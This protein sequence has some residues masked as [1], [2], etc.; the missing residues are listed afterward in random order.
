[1]EAALAAMVKRSDISIHDILIT[2]FLLL[3]ECKDTITYGLPKEN[4]K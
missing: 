2:S 1:M 3:I 4:L